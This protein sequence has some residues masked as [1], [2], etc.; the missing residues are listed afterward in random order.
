MFTFC[1]KVNLSCL[2]FIRNAFRD[3]NLIFDGLVWRF[4]RT[5]D[6][7]TP[8]ALPHHHNEDDEENDQNYRYNDA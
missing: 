6:K 3:G 4:P 2:R 7:G 8:V 5:L 1:S